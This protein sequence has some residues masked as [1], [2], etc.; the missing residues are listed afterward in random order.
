MKI[1][2]MVL[3]LMGCFEA[4]ASEPLSVHCIVGTHRSVCYYT[5]PSGTTYRVERMGSRSV[6]MTMLSDN[7][8]YRSTEVET[9]SGNVTIT[10]GRDNRGSSWSHTTV[11]TRSASSRSLSVAADLTIAN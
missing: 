3:V 11:A 6:T 5:A 4:V 7:R 10:N 9:R 1:L 8:G 2:M